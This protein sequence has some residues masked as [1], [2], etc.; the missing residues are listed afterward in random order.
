MKNY[1]LKNME[2]DL[3]QMEML[4]A[5]TMPRLKIYNC[6]YLLKDYFIDG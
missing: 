6:I 3:S 4:F 1:P 5:E 2:T